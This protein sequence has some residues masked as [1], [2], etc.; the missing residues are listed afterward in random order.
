MTPL[1]DDLTPRPSRAGVVAA[2]IVG[3]LLLAI[4]LALLAVGV[5]LL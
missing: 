2:F 5:A 3:G 4:D 1:P